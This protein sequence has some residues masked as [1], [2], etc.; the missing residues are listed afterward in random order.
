MVADRTGVGSVRLCTCR[1]GE[2]RHGPGERLA[3][4]SGEGR[5]GGLHS[6]VARD[7]RVVHRHWRRLVVL[8]G[9]G[10]GVAGGI[11]FGE[12]VAAGD[13]VRIQVEAGAA[14]AVEVLHFQLMSAGR[15][16]GGSGH[17]LKVVL[18][19]VIDHRVAVD[20]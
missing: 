17:A 3:L 9:R 13:Q 19:A 4:D 8:N 18:A 5:A 2:G 15:E 7:G 11:L 14:G 6:R 10:D 20:E 12:G 16:E 1:I